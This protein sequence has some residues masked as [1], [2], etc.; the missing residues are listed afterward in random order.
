MKANF[1]Y[2]NFIILS[3]SMLSHFGKVVEAEIIYN[4]R[5]SKVSKLFLVPIK[6]TTYIG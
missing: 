4:D 5:G 2:N 3:F 6:M 1:V